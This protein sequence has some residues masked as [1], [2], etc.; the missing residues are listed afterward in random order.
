MEDLYK[1]IRLMKDESSD[2]NL[3]E[4]FIHQIFQDLV[5]RIRVRKNERGKFIERNGQVFTGWVES[6]EKDF[7]APLV[8]S[9]LSDDELWELVLRVS[10]TT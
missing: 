4:R 10:G 2:P 9:V 1:K 7:P 6:L 8:Q 5:H 3:T